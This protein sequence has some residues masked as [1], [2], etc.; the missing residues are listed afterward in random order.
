[1]FFTHKLLRVCVCLHAGVSEEWDGASEMRITPPL[2]PG[3]Y[4]VVL[5]GYFE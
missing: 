5:W 1:M 2:L 3:Y 4:T